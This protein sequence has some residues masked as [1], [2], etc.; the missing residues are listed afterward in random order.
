M[1][2]TCLL[3]FALLLPAAVHA[4]DMDLLAPLAPKTK[5]KSKKHHRTRKHHH[6]KQE[7]QPAAPA[8][9]QPPA[10]SDD[11]SVLAPL[12]LPTALGV[13][14]GDGV[15][16]AEVFVD[17]KSWGL[18][19]IAPKEVAPG[20]HRVVVK[21]PGFADY[22]KTVNLE[23]GKKLQLNAL[24]EPNAAVL[25]VRTEPAGAEVLIDGKP[26]GMTP[27]TNLLLPPGSYELRIRHPGFMDDVS[28]IAVRA[29]RDYPVK[30]DL[31]PLPRHGD[32]PTEVALTPSSTGN[33]ALPGTP[34]AEAQVEGPKPWYK[35]WYVWAGVGVVAAAA[36][37]VAAASG[38][39]NPPISAQAVCGG[40]CDGVLN[41]P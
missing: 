32:R 16:G 21:R 25:A 3:A 20:S 1:I 18:A 35:R 30:L 19:P 4:Q 31:V 9:E 41:A 34:L 37:G 29:G 33:A 27:L 40:S 7:T 8:P 10:E 5:T 17:G 12:Q 26:V 22:A 14:V 39:S 38:G 2:R 11:L 24:L 6:P 23:S 36:V 15:T 13:K 28:R